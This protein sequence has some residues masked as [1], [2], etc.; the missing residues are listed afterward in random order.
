VTAPPPAAHPLAVALRGGLA[1]HR[2]AVLQAPTGAGKSTVVPL[3]LLQEPF[4]RGAKILLLEPRRLAARAVAARMAAG[5]N[6]RVGQTVGYRMRLDTQVSRATRIEVVTEGV[7]TRMLQEDPALEG[8]ACV[9]FDEFHERSLQADLGLAL[10]LDARRAFDSELRIVIMSATL[11]VERSALLLGDAPI[12]SVPGR[13][14]PVE[15]RYLGGGAPRL[16]D[17][18]VP[19]ER[20]LLAAIRRALDDTAGDMLVFLPGGPEIRRLQRLLEENGAQPPGTMVLPLYGDLAGEAQDAALAPAAPGTRKI[21]LATNI[22]E[23]SLTIPGVAVVVDSGLVRRS[24]FDPVSGMS[25]LETLRISRASSEQRAGRAGRTALGIC[26]RLWSESAQS[27]L[28][29]FTPPEI[30]DSDLAP[31]ALELARWGCTDAAALDWLDPPPAATL[32]QARD[33]LARLGAIDGRGKITAMGTRM[34]Q[35]PLHPRLAHMVAAARDLNAVPLAADLATLLSDRDL[36]RGPRFERDPDIR[37]RLER[38]RGEAGSGTSDRWTLQRARRT[39]ENLRRL[40]YAAGPRPST[41]ADGDDGTV[42]DTGA[43]L[44]LAFPDRIGR[45]RGTSASASTSASTSTGAGRYLLSNGRGAAF[46]GGV[47]LARAEFIVAIELDDRG[48]DARIDLAAPLQRATLEKIFAPQIVAEE[49]IAW[50]AREQ[51]VLAR[52][53]TRLE[54]L[55]LDDRPL[56]AP[57]PER[58]LRAMLDGIGQMGMEALP[59]DAE[60]RNLQARMQLVARLQRADVGDWPAS[61]DES[62]RATLDEW[63][64]P[65]LAGITRREQLARVPLAE[66]L[67]ARLTPA[68]QHKLEELAPRQLTVP[69]GSQVRIDYVDDNAPCVAVRLQEVFGLRSTPHIGGGRVPVTFKL[70]SPAQRPVQ[71]TRDLEGFWGSSYLQ[72]RRDMRGRYPKHHWPENPLEAAPTRG[73]K[74]RT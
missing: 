24:R 35:L 40:A 19:P 27:S 43:L 54:A 3:A 2:D 33:L 49:L 55:V 34:A 63:L 8:V 47:A 28:A 39:A 45:R 73:A 44:A 51:A 22:A 68:Q 57:P 41:G 9:I 62:L 59:W 25:R 50:D 42:E 74:R 6:E 5:L 65:W 18:A 37:T 66:A 4:V 26:Y 13:S 52:R 58:S 36:L 71:I 64:A 61:D 21:V 10:C 15:L 72:V 48:A 56:P 20:S 67:R 38:M 60:A 32:A 31:L 53:I 1:Q 12:V 17:G 69:S 30:L 14:F 7:L 46:E 29:A 11:D 70:L 16:P 23:T